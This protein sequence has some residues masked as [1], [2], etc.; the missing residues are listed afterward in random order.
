MVRF[1]W[2][3]RYAI[4]Q[5]APTVISPYLSAAVS[6]YAGKHTEIGI[7]P[8]K[9]LDVANLDELKPFRAVS[10]MVL[11]S[12]QEGLERLKMLEPIVFASWVSHAIPDRSPDGRAYTKAEKDTLIRFAWDN[13]DAFYESCPTFAVEDALTTARTRDPKRNPTESDGADLQHSVVGLAYCDL[14][15]S[16]D[17]YQRTCAEQAKRELANHVL[18]EICGDLKKLEAFAANL[19]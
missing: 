11:R 19:G 5:P 13:A 10:P 8:R 3:H 9:F 17:G 6:A 15:L 2:R 4:E 7:T 18:A 14:F 1:L 12:C 16:L